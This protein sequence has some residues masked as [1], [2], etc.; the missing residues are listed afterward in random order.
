MLPEDRKAE[1][2]VP[3]LSI[4]ENIALAALPALSR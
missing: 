1:G 2:I 3:T 4:R